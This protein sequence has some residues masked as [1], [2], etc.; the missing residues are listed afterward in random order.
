MSENEI[1]YKEKARE[2]IVNGVN[3]LANAVKA[4]LGPKGRNVILMRNGNYIITKDGVTVAKSINID[5]P[6]EDAGAQI[7]KEVASKTNDYAGD[8]TTTATVLAQEIVN[9][10]MKNVTAGSNPMEI[11][12]GMDK[13]VAAIIQELKNQSIPTEGYNRVK[14]IATISAN[15]DEEIGS[16]IAEAMEKAGKNGS[17]VVDMGRTTETSLV[18]TEGIEISGGY[19]SEYFINDKEKHACEYKDAYIALVNKK[20]TN[21]NDI[22]KLF[23]EV[24]QAQKPLVIIAED[25]SGDA[26]TIMAVNCSKGQIIGCG[27]K[28]P[29]ESSSKFEL[30]EDLAT[31]TGATIIDEQAGNGLSKVANPSKYFGKAGKITVKKG[32][33]TICD[34][35]GKPENIK[36]QV[37]ILNER[38]KESKTPYEK[39]KIGIRIARLTGGIAIIQTGANTDFEMKEKRDRI[40]DA[41]N[42][43]R[44][45]IDEGVVPGGGVALIKAA[46]VLDT[47]DLKGDELTGL[48]IIKAALESPCRAIAANAGVIGEVVVEQV[49]KSDDPMYGYNAATNEYGNM[50][51]MGIIDPTKVTKTALENATSIAGL[52]LTTECIVLDQKETQIAREYFK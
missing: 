48:N 14:Q 18:T 11:K 41:L 22:I 5:N 52:L 37:D 28:T 51:D 40:D 47:L 23:S 21:T 19:I 29:G 4:T 32:R 44:A 27:I 26:L 42:A 1:L 46:K 6:L 15:G 31:L 43:T 16:I 39:Q 24:G 2:N 3:K 13:S 34:G 20:I 35:E 17:V 33:T 12:R 30:L 36:A 45:A 9:M 10:G 25:I 7:V 8:G 38:L 50:F 49:K